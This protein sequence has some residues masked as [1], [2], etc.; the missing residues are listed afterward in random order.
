MKEESDAIRDCEFVASL[1]TTF[2]P[3]HGGSGDMMLVQ[4]CQGT[5]EEWSAENG[6]N[7]FALSA[8]ATHGTGS[9]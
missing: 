9:G 6:A 7:L 5:P 3:Y 8:S 4:R 2:K 1:S